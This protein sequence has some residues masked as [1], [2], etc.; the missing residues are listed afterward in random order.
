MATFADR[1]PMVIFWPFELPPPGTV[2]SS[3]AI[4]SRYAWSA[5]PR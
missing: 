5:S 2:M 3:A 4:G 1:A